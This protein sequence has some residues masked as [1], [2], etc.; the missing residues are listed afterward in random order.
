MPPAMW[1][2]EVTAPQPRRCP[3]SGKVSPLLLRGAPAA[4][5]LGRSQTRDRRG[6]QSCGRSTRPPLARQAAAFFAS[7]D[8]SRSLREFARAAS[9]PCGRAP[10]RCSWKG[11]SSPWSP[12]LPRS[13]PS[14][15]RRRCSCRIDA[16]AAGST[17]MICATVGISVE[18]RQPDV[19]QRSRCAGASLRS[20]PRSEA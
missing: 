2:G 15:E 4:P 19:R 17:E 1:E 18:P 9:L 7:S 12:M 5:E 11:L 10:P 13:P 20:S 16:M 6:A 3:A 8:R 14:V